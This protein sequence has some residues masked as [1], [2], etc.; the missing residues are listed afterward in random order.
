[1]QKYQIL[2]RD[3]MEWSKPKLC[4]KVRI[5]KLLLFF[6]SFYPIQQIIN[7]MRNSPKN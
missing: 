2:Y 4:F 5:Q 6:L 3:K 1:M 7:G